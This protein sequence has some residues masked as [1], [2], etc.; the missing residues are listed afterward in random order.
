[1]TRTFVRFEN[2]TPGAAALPW[3]EMLSESCGA[4]RLFE[5]GRIPMLAQS[6]S[7]KPTVMP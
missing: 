4:D 7:K 2:Y 1:V 6:A 3:L 5:E